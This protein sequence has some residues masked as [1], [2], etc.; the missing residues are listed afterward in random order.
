MPG[1]LR[2]ASS[3]AL[4]TCAE[5]HRKAV[6]DRHR[7]RDAVQGEGRR[8]PG[9][10]AQC[11]PI[12][13]SGSITRPIGR[14][15]R[16]AS[17]MN[18]AV[19]AW[20][21]TRPISSRVEVPEL[22]MSSA[23]RGCS[24]PP[25]PMP[26]HHPFSSFEPVDRRAPSRASRRRWTSRPPLQQPGHPRAAHRKCASMIERWLIDLSPGTLIRPVIGPPAVKRRGR[27]AE[28]S[29]ECTGRSFSMG[30]TAR[31]R[32]GPRAFDSAPRL[33]QGARRA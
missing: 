26:S 21:A 7:G 12:C 24:S 13:E 14:F 3:T 4:F 1:V 18:V 5:A 29:A 23:V 25:T 16:L 33:W 30:Y 32:E 10:A 28:E 20:L 6:A 31:G 15:E 22:P 17:P 19:M 11:A 2:P 27:G 9:A 8:P